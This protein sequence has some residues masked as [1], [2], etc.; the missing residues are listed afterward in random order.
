MPR[1]RWTLRKSAGSSRRSSRDTA[2]C[3]V[4]ARLGLSECSRHNSVRRSRLADIALSP[5]RLLL[6]DITG[7][8]R[9]AICVVIRVAVRRLDQRGPRAGAFLAASRQ[10]R[11]RSSLTVTLRCPSEARAIV[12]CS[13]LAMF[14]N[15]MSGKPDI[16]GRRPRIGPRV[17]A[18]HPSRLA[19]PAPQ[20]DGSLIVPL[21]R[22]ARP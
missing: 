4:D 19:A 6:I 14:E 17:G 15:P 11:Q 2:G 16:G 21:V 20:D 7:A 13:R 12:G 18:V 3:S 9:R 8:R 5:C 1:R 10:V 22:K